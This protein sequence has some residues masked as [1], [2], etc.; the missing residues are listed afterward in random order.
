MLELLLLLAR[1]LGYGRLLLKTDVSAPTI[2]GHLQCWKNV[3]QGVRQFTPLELAEFS[4]GVNGWIPVSYTH[5]D[6]YKRQV[7]TCRQDGSE[8]L[9]KTTL[10]MERQ[11]GRPRNQ[12]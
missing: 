1:L 6:V 4:T 12:C 5:L 3:W 7:W 2:G 10:E 8:G 9:S 11:E